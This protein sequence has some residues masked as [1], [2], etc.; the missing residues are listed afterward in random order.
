MTKYKNANAFDIL[1]SN[2]KHFKI[3]KDVRKKRNDKQATDL[4]F[5]EILNKVQY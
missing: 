2:V 4:A 3:W 5:N 1:Q